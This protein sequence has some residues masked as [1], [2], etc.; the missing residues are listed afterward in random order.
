[1]IIELRRRHMHIHCHSIDRSHRDSG[2]EVEGI[3]VNEGI[4][5]TENAKKRM[6]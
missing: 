2:S 3:T 6:S 1:M 4:L 5:A